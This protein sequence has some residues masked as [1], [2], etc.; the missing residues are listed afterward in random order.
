[1]DFHDELLKARE[2]ATVLKTSVANVKRMIYAGKLIACKVGSQW[3]IRK[4]ELTTYLEINA[5]TQGESG[6]RKSRDPIG[7]D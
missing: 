7:L 2:A 6:R 1:M 4:S 5:S 3:R